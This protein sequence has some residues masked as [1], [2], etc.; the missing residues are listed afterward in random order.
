MSENKTRISLK[1]ARTQKKV[2]W[3]S[4]R[5]DFNSNPHKSTFSGS[6]FFLNCKKIKN[7]FNFSCNNARTA[8]HIH[9]TRCRPKKTRKKQQNFLMDS[10]FSKPWLEHEQVMSFAFQ[11]FGADLLFGPTF[12]ISIHSGR[13]RIGMFQRN[14]V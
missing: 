9:R 2:G 4:I 3:L 10:C 8:Q 14:N 11:H 5:V 7:T 12:S 1:I 6:F 13:R